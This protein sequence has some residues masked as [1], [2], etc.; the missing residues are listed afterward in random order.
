MAEAAELSGAAALGCVPEGRPLYAAHA[1]LAWPDAP[2]LVLSH[3]LT[4]LREFRG[5]GHVI[6]LQV[7][8]L[9]GLAAL[10]T[11]TATGKG[12]T[13]SFARTRRGWSREQWAAGVAAL[14]ERGLS[15]RPARSLRRA[16]LCVEMSSGRPTG[17]RSSPGP[18]WAPSAPNASLRSVG[19]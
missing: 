14:V 16:R 12:F 8:E 18:R 15:S 6:A 11:H 3:A 5:D 10:I 4:L 19:S 2:H 13:E 7:A 17:W 9:D 1:E